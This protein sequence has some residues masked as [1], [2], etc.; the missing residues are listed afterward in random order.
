VRKFGVQSG[1]HALLKKKS[2]RAVVSC[3][4]YGGAGAKPPVVARAIAQFLRLLPLPAEIETDFDTDE[5]PETRR[6]A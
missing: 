2:L 6:F 4:W 3:F 5:E 1:L